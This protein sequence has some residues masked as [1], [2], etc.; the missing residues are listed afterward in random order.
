MHG[1]SLS[2]PQSLDRTDHAWAECSRPLRQMHDRIGGIVI[3]QDLG[4]LLR[5]IA[6]PNAASRSIQRIAFV[7]RVDKTEANRLNVRVTQ[8]V[9]QRWYGVNERDGATD[10][11]QAARGCDRDLGAS[12][13]DM[14]VI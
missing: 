6:V 10:V 13:I 9:G 8:L 7:P 4:E 11:R 5:G 2:Q 3:F 14:S 1:D 12:A